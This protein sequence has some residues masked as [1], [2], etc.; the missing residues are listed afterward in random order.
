MTGI[1]EFLVRLSEGRLHLGE[2]TIVLKPVFM[3]CFG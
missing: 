3:T 2:S 1:V